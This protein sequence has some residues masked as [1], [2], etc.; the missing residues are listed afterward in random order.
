MSMEDVKS[1][2]VTINQAV[3]NLDP[4]ICG[5]LDEPFRKDCVA[6]VSLAS[7]AVAAKNQSLCFSEGDVPPHMRVLCMEQVI[8]SIG[9]LA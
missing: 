6:A 4:G 9:G 2:S 7:K 3:E 8:K 1:S 5:K